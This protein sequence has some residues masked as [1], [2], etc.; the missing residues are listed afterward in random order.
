MHLNDQK[1][2]DKK[3]IIDDLD[4]RHLLIK[5]D[6]RE[7]ISKKVD[8]WM[9]LVRLLSIISLRIDILHCIQLIYVV[10]CFHT[11]HHQNVFSSIERVGESLDTS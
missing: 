8:E 1:K 7:E 4:A 10:F 6:V 5:G 3:F 9:D 11:I 2:N